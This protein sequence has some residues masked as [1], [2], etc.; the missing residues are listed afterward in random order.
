MATTNLVLIE[1]GGSTTFERAAGRLMNKL[2]ARKD[3]SWLQQAMLSMLAQ[4]SRLS[5]LSEDFDA[6]FDEAYKKY[7]CPTC[8]KK[9]VPQEAGLL[10]CIECSAAQAERGGAQ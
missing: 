5:Q 2:M 4:E 9:G 6:F 3:W 8:G 10:D 7:G 1:G